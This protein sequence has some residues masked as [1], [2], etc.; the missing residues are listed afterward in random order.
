M[1][2]PSYS[3]GALTQTG[4]VTVPGA[5]HFAVGANAIT[6]TNTNNSFTGAVTLNNSGVNNVSLTNSIALQLA[7]SS[8]GNNLTLVAGGDIT[9]TGAVIAPNGVVTVTVTAANSN[10]LLDTQANDFGAGSVTFGGSGAQKQN[11]QD[12][13]IRSINAAA[14]LPSFAGLTNLRNLTVYF[15]AAPIAFPAITLT[16][17]GNLVATANVISR[18]PVN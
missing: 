2:W 8:I 11:I 18:K 14:S 3:S 6:L 12:V 15:D 13:G 5:T 17:G 4:A 7:A 1:T 10:I 9:E 16:N